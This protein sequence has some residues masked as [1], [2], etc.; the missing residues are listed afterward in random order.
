MAKDAKTVGSTFLAEVLAKLPEAERAKAQEVFAG[1]AAE[2]ALVALGEGALRQSDYSR[3]S[4][5]IRQKE[6]EVDTYKG[7]L[8]TWFAE[9]KPILEEVEVLRA[10]VAGQP[11]VVPPVVPP[12]APAFD[13]SKFV[14]P[15]ALTKTLEATERGALQFIIE[16]NKLAQQHF[17]DFGEPL[18]LAPLVQHKQVQQLGLDGV[19]RLVHAEQIATRATAAADAAREA[20]RKEER[21]KLQAE[22]ARAQTPYPVRGNE[23]STLDAIEAARA[24]TAPT[25]RTIDDMANEYIRLGGTRPQ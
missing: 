2:A 11:P 12:A 17:K 8:D 5:E 3:A 23:P 18:D 9:K 13:P 20:I 6:A 15:E 7:Q 25:I 4:N 1:A 19:Y 16:S 24:G 22:M 10:K 21:E 14:S